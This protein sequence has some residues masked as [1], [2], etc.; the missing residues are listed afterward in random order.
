[1]DIDIIELSERKA[2]F[3]LSGVASSFANGLRRSILAEVPVMA[4]DEVNIYEN[5]SVLFDEQ[6]ALRLGLI[7]LKAPRNTYVLPEECTCNGV[8]CVSCK[9][10]LTLS[11]EGSRVA[12][13]GDMVS[14]DPLVEVADKK[15]PIVDLKDRHKVVVE[16]IARLGTGRK[17]S[18]WQAGIAAG[19]KNM[20]IITIGDCDYCGG[21]VE[22]CPRNILKIDD[23]KVKVIN[24]IDCSLCGMCE[25]KCGMHSIKVTS[26][27][28]SFIM[29]YETT[30]AMTA[31][32]IAI[33]AMG[34]IK[35]RAEM[36]SQIV[37]AL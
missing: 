28:N 35:K 24:L 5:T 36:F 22:V 30:G 19:Y 1:M 37:D 6:F 18:K 21:C 23:G 26:D 3:V 4:I 20:P 13:S 11:A 12:Y 2:R 9:V 14:A 32:E 27:P 15:V 34:D 16:A 31:A 17:H 33:E 10:S 25:E 29:T 8:G 7:P